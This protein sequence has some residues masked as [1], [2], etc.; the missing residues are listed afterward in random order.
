MLIGTHTSRCFDKGLVIDYREGRGYKTRGG[1][2]K[3][4]FSRTKKGGGG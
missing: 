2:G 4:S 1:G 3:R